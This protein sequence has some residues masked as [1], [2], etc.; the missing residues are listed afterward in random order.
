MKYLAVNGWAADF[1]S[2][3]CWLLA[4]VLLAALIVGVVRGRKDGQ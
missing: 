1:S 3:A 4:F 2:T